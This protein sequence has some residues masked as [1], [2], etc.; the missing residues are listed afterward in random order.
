MP[1][2]LPAS[3]GWNLEIMGNNFSPSIC[4]CTPGGAAAKAAAVRGPPD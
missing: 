4:F 2:I 3:S 1:V